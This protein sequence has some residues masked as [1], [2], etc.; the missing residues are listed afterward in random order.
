MLGDK[1][2]TCLGAVTSLDYILPV[3]AVPK[4]GLGTRG[5]LVRFAF[6]PEPEPEPGVLGWDCGLVAG[7]LKAGLL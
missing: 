6:P 2:H 7:D 4:V 1:S 3:A 5:F